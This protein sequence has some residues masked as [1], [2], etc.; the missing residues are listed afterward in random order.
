LTKEEKSEKFGNV[1]SVPI[2]E[3]D[4]D[5]LREVTAQREGVRMGI[6]TLSQAAGDIALK[7]WKL[8]DSFRERYEFPTDDEA[9]VWYDP[10][11]KSIMWR[12]KV[13]GV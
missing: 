1:G 11:S 10:L 13:G 8:W 2:S 4:S 6:R 7:S 9:R 3:Y 5:R 12:K